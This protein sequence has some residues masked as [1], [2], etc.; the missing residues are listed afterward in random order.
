MIKDPISHLLFMDDLKRYAEDEKGIERRI[1]QDKDQP[2]E[3]GNNLQTQ[4]D[5]PNLKHPY[6]HHKPSSKRQ[7]WKTNKRAMSRPKR[8]TLIKTAAFSG[9][10]KES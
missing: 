5:D 9:C 7:R 8:A 3:E 4:K 10:K 2:V 6:F 1:E